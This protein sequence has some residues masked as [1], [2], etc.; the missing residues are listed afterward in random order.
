M[1]ILFKVLKI[2]ERPSEKLKGV[3]QISSGDWD[4]YSFK[5]SFAIT[6]FDQQGKRIDF[7]GVKIGYVGQPKGWTREKIPET[8]DSLPEGWFSLG[9]DVE[10]YKNA[11]SELTAEDRAAMLLALRDVVADETVL[12]AARDQNVFK[13]SLMRDVSLSVIDG[14]FK[15]VLKGDVELSDFHF[16]FVQ[17]RD[18]RHA[19]VSLNFKVDAASKPSTNVHVLIG[20]N[21]VGKTTL[22]NNMVGALLKVPRDGQPG[23]GFYEYGLFS[24]KEVLK[25]EYFS[26]VVS[27]SFSAFDPFL[28][29]EDRK[30]R[31][32]GPAYFYI[33]MKNARSGQ[34]T[35]Q[36]LP[37]KTD[38]EL[39]N[40][41][42]ASLRS[43]LQQPA[44]RSRWFSAIKRLESDTNF[45]EMDLGRLVK[46]EEKDALK[47]AGSTAGRMSSG[48]S[49]VLLTITKLVET[50]EEKTLVLLDEPESHLHPPLLSA[51]TRALSDLLHGRN[52]VAIVATHSPVV[53]QEVPRSCVWKLTRSR[54]EGRSDR[55]ERETFGEN[56]GILTREIFGLEVSKSG[57]HEMMQHA[58]DAGD[59]YEGIVSAYGGQ[60]GAEARAILLS[61]IAAR[62]SGETDKP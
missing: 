19:P 33:G 9:Q 62:E 51:F 52:G 29:P 4:D 22:L 43:C 26:S 25:R 16:S 55:P 36:R 47:A 61:L 20:R 53:L 27:V 23:Y 56:V 18:E 46:M 15:R 45:A 57:F 1:H 28:P 8:F 34:V 7:G 58:V 50:V 38:A 21:G 11:V 41:F 14:Q 60:I 10:Y 35:A 17:E 12:V 42:I 3:F 48:H 30:D 31:T 24:S 40:D 54:T 32:L 37:P 39:V 59:T 49:I 2:K 44:K 5:T 6:L 13:D